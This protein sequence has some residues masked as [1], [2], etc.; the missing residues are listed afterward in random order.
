MKELIVGPSG[1]G[2]SYVSRK[3]SEMGVNAFDADAVEGL[4]G[5]FDKDGK[6]ANFSFDADREFLEN[7]SFLWNREFLKDY[8][9]SHT[10][11]MYLFGLSENVFDMLDLF[12]K[13][14]YFFVPDEEI[15]KRLSSEERDN[16]FG[17]SEVQKQIILEFKRE[18]DERARQLGLEF[19][20]STKS[21]E[22]VY[23]LIKDV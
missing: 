8:L 4:C 17:K 1:S 15:E 2:K 23:A 12:D 16:P 9:E 13:A 7:H 22:E 21:P 10:E 18:L 19:I 20:D 6:I 5:W 14:Y 11:E 3:I